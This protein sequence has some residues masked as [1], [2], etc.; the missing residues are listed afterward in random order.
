[1][2]YKIDLVKAI[3]VQISESDEHAAEFIKKMSQSDYSKHKVV[4]RNLAQMSFVERLS[5]V[6]N[7]LVCC[8]REFWNDAPNLDSMNHR[9]LFVHNVI[10]VEMLSPCCH[11]QILNMHH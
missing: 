10:A 2:K 7:S 11:R 3:H 9:L 4:D 6:R 5:F 8:N 1:M